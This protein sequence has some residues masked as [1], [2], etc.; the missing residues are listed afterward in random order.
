MEEGT[1]SGAG[2]NDPS[3]VTVL[4]TSDSR[5]LIL[6]GLIANQKIHIDVNAKNAKG[7]G[8]YSD[9]MSFSAHSGNLRLS[10]HT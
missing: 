6:K 2:I 4:E 1:V 9:A 10:A 5:K 7:K 3:W 8:M